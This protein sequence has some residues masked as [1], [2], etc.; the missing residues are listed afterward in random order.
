MTL[1]K[2]LLMDYNYKDYHGN[3]QA[4]YKRDN[5]I[6]STIVLWDQDLLGLRKCAIFHL[7]QW[8]NAAYFKFLVC[9]TWNGYLFYIP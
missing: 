1:K 3:L 7:F 9:Y 8:K 4:I 2:Q 6:R 5:K